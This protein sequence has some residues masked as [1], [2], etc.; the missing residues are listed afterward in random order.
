MIGIKTI[1]LTKGKFATVDAEDYENLSQHKWHWADNGGGGYAVRCAM[2]K[3]MRMHRV[4][5]NCPRDMVVDHI[6]GDGLD[7][8]KGNLRV[9]TNT[10]N[11]QSRLTFKNNSSGQKG[12][13]YRK[14]SRKWR[15]RLGVR[16]KYITLGNFETFEEAK[17]C[18]IT[19]AKE[20]Y[21][22]FFK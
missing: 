11:I 6:N 17:R 8:R 5:T 7:N 10:Q 1:P 19:R 16:G 2:R 4:I 20:E 22:E 15:A 13:C 3:S 9:C 18:Y 21:G 14:D 12:V